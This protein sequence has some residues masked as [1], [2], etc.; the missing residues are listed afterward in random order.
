[1]KIFGLIGWSGSGKTT[2]L[3]S[4][5]PAVI[6]RGFTVSTVKHTSHAI[7]PDRPGKDSYRHRLAGATDVVLLS[8]ARMILF[9][10]VHGGTEPTL[11]AILPRL[12][13]VDL[14]LV[15]GFKNLPHD[16]LEVHRPAVG[17][18]LICTTDPRIVAVASDVPLPGLDRRVLDLSD[19]EAIAD[20][21]IAHCNLHEAG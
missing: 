9:H 14:L 20:F 4:L 6:R 3:E 19:V 7:D 17:K 2:L 8:S 10:E 21:V 12:A 18:P 1:M 11:D 16:R 5:L 13:P 15:E